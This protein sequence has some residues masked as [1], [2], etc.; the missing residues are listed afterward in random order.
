MTRKRIALLVGGIATLTLLTI[1]VAGNFVWHQF[2]YY[3]AL[4]EPVSAAVSDYH[5]DLFRYEVDAIAGKLFDW[6]RRPG[7]RL[8]VEEQKELVEQYRWRALRMSWLEDDIE[9]IYADPTVPDP[10]AASASLRRQLAELRDVQ[11]EARPL[12]EAIL[13]RQV[14]DKLE[15]VGLT[16]AGVLW[17]PVRFNFSDL[18]KYLIVSP[19]DRIEVEAGVQLRSDLSLPE[20]EDIENEV[21]NE[22]DRST[23]IEGL[24]GLGV[25]PTMVMSDSSL[26]WTLNTIAHEWVHTYLAFHPLGWNMFDSREMNIINETVATI[27]GDE[28][29]QTV[30]Y[31]VYGIPLP[32]PPAADE[33]ELPE[34]DPDE[35][36]FRTEMR[37]TR[38]KVDELLE[39]GRVEEAEAYMEQRRQLFVEHGYA[40]RKLNQAYFAFHG[41]YATR[42]AASDP[43]GPKLQELRRLTPDLATFVHAV[44][45]IATPEDLDS[46]LAEWRERSGSGAT[47]RD[48][49]Y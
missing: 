26:S 17:P 22:F 18:P 36:D 48:F 42:A 4:E 1:A 24:G 46:L 25:W 11:E 45:G 43:I 20:I 27:V 40:I 39:A 28:V 37:R 29:G 5:F 10:E 13:E 23:L 41:N 2:D 19:R 7:A 12:V 38:L 14:G 33:A 21:A 47:G 32:S 44:Q 8:T 30:A 49:G 9:R 15:Q 34:P 16:T 31:E 3:G 6:W 35:F